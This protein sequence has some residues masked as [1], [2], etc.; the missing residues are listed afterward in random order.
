MAM[1]I[2]QEVAA[3]HDMACLME[4]KPFAGINGSGKHNNFSLGTDTGIN[5]LNAEQ[6]TDACGNSAVFGS[7][8]ALPQLQALQYPC[9]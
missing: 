2:M 6:V 7:L 9:P 4:E 3:K 8:I 5:L 1:Q